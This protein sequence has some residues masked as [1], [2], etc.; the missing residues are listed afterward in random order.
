MAKLFLMREGERV[1]QP[2]EELQKLRKEAQA[3]VEKGENQKE[4][5]KI[6]EFVDFKLLQEM[7]R[8]FLISR[9][10]KI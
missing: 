7:L 4:L 1:P 3:Q 6:L 8:K 2:P 5:D 9:S 10:I